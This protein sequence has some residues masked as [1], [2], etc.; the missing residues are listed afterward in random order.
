MHFCLYV[1]SHNNF[2]A[3]AL[4]FCGRPN[5]HTLTYTHIECIETVFLYCYKKG[6]GGR[7]CTHTDI[8]IPREN[9]AWIA[10]VFVAKYLLGVITMYFR[11]AFIIAVRP[12]KRK[13]YEIIVWRVFCISTLLHRL[14]F[15]VKRNTILKI[16]I[17]MK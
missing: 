6:E 16:V 9:V 12:W 1:S 10:V 11:T 7:K 2:I 17:N 4:E 13:R 5:I 3:L 14:F 15:Y 8:H